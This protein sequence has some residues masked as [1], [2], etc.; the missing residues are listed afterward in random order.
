MRVDPAVLRRPNPA[1]ERHLLRSEVCA[2]RPLRAAAHDLSA[3]T[4]AGEWHVPAAGPAAA[5]PAARPSAAPRAAPCDP[6]DAP[7]NGQP[8]AAHAVARSPLRRQ[9]GTAH[10]VTL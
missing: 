4:D 3:R 9:R 2:R 6:L 5:P 7:R 1:A 10:A 8:D